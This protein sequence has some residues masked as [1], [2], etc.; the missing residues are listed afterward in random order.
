MRQRADSR[1]TAALLLWSGGLGIRIRL[2][3]RL[4]SGR[5]SGAS[6]RFL[7]SPPHFRLINV[8]RLSRLHRTASAKRR[9]AGFYI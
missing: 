1:R 9:I 7:N 2:L 6:E 3:L 5:W 4:C 8:G